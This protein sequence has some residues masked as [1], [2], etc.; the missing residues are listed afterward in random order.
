MVD[1]LRGL[2]LRKLKQVF[3]DEQDV[4]KALGLL[5]S[6]S[7]MSNERESVRGPLAVLELNGDNLVTASSR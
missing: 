5:D 2:L 4:R 7:T 6:Y 3:P 1:D